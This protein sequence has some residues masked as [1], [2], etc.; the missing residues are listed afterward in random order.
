MAYCTRIMAY[1][2]Y[3]Q[4]NEILAN[5]QQEHYEECIRLLEGA[6]LATDLALYFRHRGEFFSLV[7]SNKIDWNV[8]NHR[9]LL[10]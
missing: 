4:G 2:L 8:E 1:C 3:F 6:I 10:R 9:D 5:L 7:D